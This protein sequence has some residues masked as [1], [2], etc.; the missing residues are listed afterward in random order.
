[1]IGSCII[2]NVDIWAYGAF[3]ERD[4]SNDFLSF[5]TRRTPDFNDWSEYDGLEVDL[6]DLSFEA[7]KVSV[8]YV[9]LGDDETVFKQR[10]NAFRTLHFKA[11]YRNVYVR[12]FNKT[13]TLRFVGFSR[14]K[15]KGGMVNN[16]SKRGYL[17]AD[18]IMDDPLQMYSTAIDTPIS[19]SKIRTYT[20]I[21]Q[22]GLSQFGIIVQDVYSTALRPASAKKVL[23]RKSDHLDGMWADV[24]EIAS[25]QLHE[26]M[27]D[28]TMKANSVSELNTNLTALFNNMNITTP[29]TVD[30]AGQRFACYYT[31]MSRFKKEAPF[32]RSV[33][34][35]FTLHLQ[36]FSEIQ[37]ARILATQS[38]I[39][40][41]TQSGILISLDV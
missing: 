25:T 9:I 34:V 23:E 6:S 1:M 36:E 19:Q 24:D 4:G 26:V 32:K 21:N 10:L 35:S 38:N 12:E 5:P 30:V 29:L 28:C 41:I 27:I 13:F 16:R 22:I 2:D 3:I 7:K 8:N 33:R 15:H 20:K 18:Y 14:Y 37:I 39:A 31:K 11:G 40:L 17:T